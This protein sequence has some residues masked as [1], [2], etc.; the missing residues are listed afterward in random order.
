[1]Y[2]G[3]TAL[4]IA[5]SLQNRSSQAEAVRLLLRRGADPG[6]KNNE[7]E[8]PAQLVPTGPVGDKVQA[9]SLYHRS[10]KNRFRAKLLANQALFCTT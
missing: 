7:N 9:L 5:S 4:H 2:N 1:M 6:T 10:L 8:L 3:N